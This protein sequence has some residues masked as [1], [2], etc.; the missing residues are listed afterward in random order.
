MKQNKK[1]VKQI[2][3]ILLSIIMV[4]CMMPSMAFA[5]DGDAETLPEETVKRE[6]L[7][8]ENLEISTIHEDGSQ[9]APLT[10][11]YN[12]EQ[13][14]FSASLAN[15]TDLKE[16]N[17]AD[18]AISLKN[19]EN[20]VTAK[21]MDCSGNFISDFNDSMAATTGKSVAKVGTYDYVIALD[22]GLKIEEYQVQLKKECTF[23]WKT[24]NFEALPEFSG[25]TYHGEPEGTL[26][27][28]DSNGNL[29]G[30]TG[31]SEDCFQYAVYLSPKVSRIKPAGKNMLNIYKN[32]TYM[33]NK[34]TSVY[35]NGEEIIS[36]KA[37]A[38][39]LAQAWNLNGIEAEVK[40]TRTELLVKAE[41]NEKETVNT[42]ITFIKEEL[43]VDELIEEINSIEEE[44]LVYPDDSAYAETLWASYEACTEEEKASIQTELREKLERIY[45]RLSW[46]RVPSKLEIL[47]PAKRLVYSPGQEF[48]AE[49]IELLATYS[50]GTTRKITKGFTVEPNGPLTDEKE[51]YLVY[52]TVRV[53]QPIQLPSGALK[54]EGT[55][56]QPY[57]IKTTEDLEKISLLSQ[58]GEKFTGK[59]F[60]FAADVTLP[61]KWKPIGVTL[62]GSNNIQ[63][64][65]NLAAFEGIIDGKNYTLTVPENG[66][67]LLGFV[68]GA[69]VRNLNIFGKKIAGYGLVNH[70]EGVGLS[71]SAIVIENVTL[72]SG[73]ATLKSGLLGA[74]ITTNGFAGCSALFVATVRNC[75]IEENVTI[76]YNK[77]QSQIGSI[78]GRM[79]GVVENCVS[80][81]DVYGKNF[82]GGIIGCKDNA[83][84]T[85]KVSGCTFNGS[86]TSDGTNVGGIVGGSYAGGAAPNAEHVTITNCK[87]EGRIEGNE[88][89]GGI[90]GGEVSIAQTWGDYSFAGNVFAGKVR[91]NKKVGAIIGYHYNLNQKDHI[92]GNFYLVDCGAE[93]GIGA[94]KY[95]DTNYE[96]PTPVEGTLYFNTENGVEDC[97]EVYGCAWKK[98]H[99][100]TDDPLGKDKESL[101]KAVR[102]IPD[103]ICYDLSVSGEYKTTYYL[104][105]ELDFDNAVFTAMWTDGTKTHPEMSDI[106]F[107]GFNNK[108][109][110]VQTVTASYGDA[111]FSFEVVVLEKPVEGK[112]TVTVHLVIKGD[113]AHDSEADGQ[114]H[115]QKEGNLTDWTERKT[116]VLPLNATVRDA[117]EEAV[118][119]TDIELNVNAASTYGWYL[120]GMKKG[121]VVLEELT[122][123][124]LS[125][126]MYT[127]N[128]NHPEVG[129]AAYFLKDND[130]IIWHYTD[131]YTKEQGSDK[132]NPPVV[133]PENPGD[134]EIDDPNTPLDPGPEA[135]VG[136]VS[137]M[138]LT[139]RSVRTDK[140]NVKVTVKMDKASADAIKELKEM[141]YAVKYTY[142]RSTKKGSGYKS[143]LTKAA[144]TYTNTTG[145]KGQMYYYKVQLRVYDKDG[146]LVAKTALKQCKYANRIWAKK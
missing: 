20:G 45:E 78:A 104:G 113:D 35:L 32:F 92:T 39:A 76:G 18:I 130:E 110:A 83:I 69:E 105:E 137:K 138:K 52:N 131:D 64:G 44:K 112:D 13:G 3:A 128:G 129:A 81:A 75:T 91:G 117:L 108:V 8:A 27:Q 140:K 87:S 47:K 93:Q 136:M 1:T 122:N 38:M 121:N 46:D 71:G 10:L 23:K 144:K 74:N 41:I 85:C 109:R 16:Y 135:V 101:T 142:Y 30:K 25:T 120:I 40:G 34:P 54:G 19:L 70:F 65:K 133:D 86:V 7:S 9:G 22:D 50:D 111:Q 139:A 14:I 59:Y 116:L 63:S 15:Y 61:E 31:P 11:S 146:K 84:G 49:G 56:E 145:K 4:L 125:G 28:L 67:P 12:Q 94:V 42:T 48:N 37:S 123:G 96:N 97:P 134:S 127:V 5:N 51:V 62:D 77:D 115:T 118:K 2:S 60:E 143:T 24:L 29:T 119:G 73:S 53:A 106:K 132:W 68:K 36:R 102:E 100:R 80:Y 55:Q 98:A 89:V 95:V 90:L 57:I 82:V 17:D 43:G 6:L 114:V 72:K 141:G 107:T 79:Q 126:W 58:S 33:P 103:K 124:P 21:L 66:L 88:N 99:N 26:F